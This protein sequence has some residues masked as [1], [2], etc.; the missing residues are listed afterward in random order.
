MILKK[1]FMIQLRNKNFSLTLSFFPFEKIYG[2]LEAISCK[3]IMTL[4]LVSEILGK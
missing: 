2:V 1:G 3:V 4:N